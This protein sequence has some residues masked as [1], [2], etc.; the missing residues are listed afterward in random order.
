MID[1]GSTVPLGTTGLQ[2]SRVGI[3]TA[4]LGNMLAPVPDEVAD[5]ALGE[6]VKRGLRYFD[7]APLYGHGLAEQRVGRAV[8]KLRRSDA[9]VSTKVGR[10]L[11]AD[12]PRDETQYYKGEPFYKD[13]PPV[14]PV[15]DFSYD[16]IMTSLEESL[17]RL[18]LDR[19]DMLLLHDPDNHYEQAATTGYK[20]LDALRS[21][22][23]VTAIGAGMNQSPMLAQLVERCDLDAVLC[24]G[25]YTLL[26]QG[27][28]DDLMPACERTTTSV[29]IGGVFN[30]GV[31]IAPGA[32]A[33]YDYVPAP[34]D[35]I[36]RARRIKAVCD[37]FEVPLPAAAL[38]FP[39]AHPRVSTVLIGFRSLAELEHD[40]GWLQTPIPIDL[41]AE[42]RRQRL[43]REDAPIPT[44]TIGA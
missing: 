4:P 19:V 17:G 11:R 16:G 21:E 15:W 10:L 34:D 41:W 18:A 9:I 29:V 31:L 14:G 22:G 2:V 25:R 35:V 3:G 6:A 38:Q 13:T 30:S 39:L 1:L 27:A 44:E 43:I 40:L 32:G 24:A 36:E 12:A 42:L 23:T 5:A 33:L 7:T 26:E 8:A 37:L 20:A 28:L